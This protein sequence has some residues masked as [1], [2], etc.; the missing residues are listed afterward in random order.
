LNHNIWWVRGL[1]R[2]SCRDKWWSL[3]W[4]GLPILA[5]RLC[6][7]AIPLFRFDYPGDM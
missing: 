5:A 4:M 7:P 6:G 1:L 2:R 3:R